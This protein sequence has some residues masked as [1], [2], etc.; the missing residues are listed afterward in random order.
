M[1]L[2][3]RSTA[4]RHETTPAAGESRRDRRTMARDAG[5]GRVSVV[6]LVGGVASSI[7]ASVVLIGTAAALTGAVNFDT[8]LMRQEWRNLDAPDAAIMSLALFLGWMLGG[9]VAGRMAR[10]SGATH[11]FYTWVLGAVLLVGAVAGVNEVGRGALT[12]SFDALGIPTDFDH[13]RDLPALAGLSWALTALAGACVG[14]SL[15]ERWHSRLVARA[16]D[17]TIGPG[18]A[19]RAEA[20]PRLRRDRGMIDVDE[21]LSGPVHDSPDAETRDAEAHADEREPAPSV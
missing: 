1:G 14:G 19:K 16:A 13:W 4:R 12:R 15:A 11:G 2:R 18:A 8:D 6:S 9:Y 5:L 7:T 17:P 20:G 10:R 21:R 3:K